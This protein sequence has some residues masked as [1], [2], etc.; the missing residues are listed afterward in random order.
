MCFAFSQSTA[1]VGARNVSLMP[2]K[3]HCHPLWKS[4]GERKDKQMHG[5]GA[6]VPVS[7]AHFS[8]FSLHRMS[9]L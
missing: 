2:A 3:S 6:F 4:L 7:L 9:P 8:Y 1:V 5:R